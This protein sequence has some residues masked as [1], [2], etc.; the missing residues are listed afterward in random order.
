MRVAVIRGDISKALFIADV[1]AKSQSNASTEAPRGNAR[2]VGRP[3]ATNIQA[4][5]DAQGLAAVA[6]T[7]ITATVPVGGPVD[8]SS[9]TIT[10]VAGLGGATGTQVAALQELL[11][12]QFVETDA[13]KKSFLYGNLAGY[14]SANFNPDPRRSPA[15]SNGA[16]I[17][18]VQDDGSTPYTVAAPVLTTADLDTPGAGQLR[19]TG[20]NLAGYGLYTFAVI[21]TGTGTYSANGKPKR[22]TQAQIITAGGSINSGGTQIDIPASLIPGLAVTTTS[23][24]VQVNDMLTASVALT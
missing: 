23:A 15:L 14:R 18:L 24:R 11:A 12:P 20:T 5:L 13:V 16:A 1:E 19:L 8:V 2:Y 9:A 17:A 22:L 7:L 3:N 6:A 21:L 4:Y 10:G